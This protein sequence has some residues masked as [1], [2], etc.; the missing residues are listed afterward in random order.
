MVLYSSVMDWKYWLAQ[1]KEHSG[2]TLEQL[3]DVIGWTKQNVGHMMKGRQQPSL[4]Q[5]ISISRATGFPLP[6]EAMGADRQTSIDDLPPAQRVHQGT[7]IAEAVHP[8]RGVAQN[9]S[10]QAFKVPPLKTREDVLSGRN[11]GE[12]F[13]YTVADDATRDTYPRGLQIIFRT[14]GQP[15]IGKAVLVAHGDDVHVRIYGQGRAAGEWT[16]NAEA[17]GYLSFSSDDGSVI[18]GYYKG[19]IEADD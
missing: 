12:L 7:P 2:L 3:G 4:D 19:Q 13:T 18:K 17:P 5:L 15:K 6:L 9:V 11:L 8:L 14:I 1:A 10:Y 16:A